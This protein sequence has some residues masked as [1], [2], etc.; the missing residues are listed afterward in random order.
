DDGTAGGDSPRR[1]VHRDIR[2][3]PDHPPGW[4]AGMSGDGS[5]FINRELSWLAFNERVLE[6][7]Q[8]RATPL[9]ERL[10]FV[11]IVAS[12]LDEF[13]MVRVARLQHAVEDGDE[14][15]DVSGLTP[16][17]QL[18]PVAVRAH[19]M[20]ASLYRLTMD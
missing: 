11:A 16:S 6:E 14:V 4:R 20:V 12:N 13:F 18:A 9:L 7:A 17:Q 8:D 2:P 10:K 1:H 15:P 19:A 5:L 3:G